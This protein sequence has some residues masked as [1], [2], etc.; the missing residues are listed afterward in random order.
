[1]LLDARVAECFPSMISSK[2]TLLR[3]AFRELRTEGSGPARE[4]VAIGVGVF[5]A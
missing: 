4:A 1:M 3:R 2:T 5:I